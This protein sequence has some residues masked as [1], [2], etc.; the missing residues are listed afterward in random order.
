ML[1]RCSLTGEETDEPAI[2]PRGVIYD[3]NSIIDYLR[4]HDRCPVDNLPLK[5]IDLIKLQ[6]S[7]TKMM[8]GAARATSFLS[9]LQS[10]ADEWNKAQEELFHTRKQLEQCRKELTHAIYKRDAA[11]NVL[12]KL[13][14]DQKLPDVNIP[15]IGYDNPIANEIN[16][17]SK[18]S[19]SFPFSY[20]NKDESI[21][22]IMSFREKVIETESIVTSVCENS[23][24]VNEIV[25]GCQ[26]GSIIVFNFRND[27]CIKQ[28]IHDT[29]ISS[30]SY[31]KDKRLYLITSV[32][33]IFVFR[34]ADNFTMEMMYFSEPDKDKGYF[35]SSFWH[36]SN[37]Y[38]VSIYST[39]YTKIFS[40]ESELTYSRQIE[41]IEEIKHASIHPDGKWICITTNT[42]TILYD[43]VD[44]NQ[45]PLSIENIEYSLFSPNRVYLALLSRDYFYVTNLRNTDCST[46]LDIPTN[47]KC[48]WAGSLSV[49]GISSQCNILNFSFK[50]EDQEIKPYRI[51]E[52]KYENIDEPSSYVYGGGVS[53]SFLI[54]Y[55]GNKVHVRSNNV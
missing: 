8:S 48:S 47:S 37:Q 39:G 31:N 14:S 1:C 5:D 23:L 36:P 51:S 42:K 3:Y 24:V 55:T 45:V 50:I 30:I 10:I 17:F 53:P 21:K 52:S 49:L 13:L 18:K 54:R 4:D 32:D 29:S 33:H 44:G 26:D 16:S 11:K 46:R 15:D 27:Q 34:I 6:V 12:A 19:A 41:D 7:D 20:I 38:V 9:H 35:V 43:L 40:L 22:R 2:T 25:V 28:K